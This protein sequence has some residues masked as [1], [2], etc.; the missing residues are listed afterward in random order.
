MPLCQSAEELALK[1]ESRILRQD[2]CPRILLSCYRARNSGPDTSLKVTLLLLRQKQSALELRIHF[3]HM[4]PPQYSTRGPEML[5]SLLNRWRAQHPRH[6]QPRHWHPQP[7]QPR[8]PRKTYQNHW[9]YNR[10]LALYPIIIS[11]RNSVPS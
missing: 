6:L 4:H 8:K 3:I 5:T 11:V 1:H 2:E 7:P 9:H 10:F